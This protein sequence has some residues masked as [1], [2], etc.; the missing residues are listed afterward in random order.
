MTAKN[1]PV[2]PLASEPGN[3][4]RIARMEA[5]R[6][7]DPIVDPSRCTLG[8]ECLVYCPEGAISLE[9]GGITFSSSLCKGC[10][11]CA[12]EC[13]E[14]AIYMRERRVECN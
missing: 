9:E 1:L 3:A 10:G 13:P 2:T 4:A 12:N 5:W 11:I 8:L 7:A 6:L 14:K